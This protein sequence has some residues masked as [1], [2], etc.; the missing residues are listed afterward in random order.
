MA[1]N[2]PDKA[3]TFIKETGIEGNAKAYGSYEALL[4]DPDVQAV[5]VP[6]PAG[7][8]PWKSAT[9]E[10]PQRLCDFEHEILCSCR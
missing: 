2:T 1:S 10:L 6:L 5:Y 9:A 7:A 3:E 4:D 8:F